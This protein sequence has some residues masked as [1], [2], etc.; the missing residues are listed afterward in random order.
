[1]ALRTLL[2]LAFATI[3]FAQPDTGALPDSAADGVEP[4]TRPDPRPTIFGF[5]RESEQHKVLTRLLQSTSNISSTLNIPGSR[6]TVF[7]P[8]DDAFASLARKLGEDGSLQATDTDA[9]IAAIATVLRKIDSVP[10]YLGVTGILFYHVINPALTYD[11]LEEMGSVK[12]LV[13]RNLTFEDDRI[14]D[15][16]PSRESTSASP[17]NVFCQNGWVNSIF[18]VLLPFDSTRA[19]EISKGITR[20]TPVGTPGVTDPDTAP[21]GTP[22]PNATPDPD[23]IGPVTVDPDAS[24]EPSPTPEDGVC[25]PASATVRLADGRS[26]TMGEL[27]AGHEVVHNEAGGA[28]KV[29]LFT[30]RMH[31]AETMFYRITTAVGHAVTMTGSHYLYVNSHLAAADSV[32]VGDHVRTTDGVSVVTDVRRVKGVGLFAP[33]TQHG[34][35]VVDGIVVSG[36]SRAVSPRLAHALLLPVRFFAKWAGVREP[37]GA[38]FYE[39]GMGLERFVLGGRTRY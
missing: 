32:V 25:F 10:G 20:P 18:E 27:E 35:L 6:F 30:H 33:H 2:L 29:F 15:G 14:V 22:D 24:E 9:V 7:A 3:A 11:M 13:N 1:M 34:D 39:G 8:T 5:I 16:D 31:V 36:Y 21:D 4:I 38:T 26:L 23:S 17:K 28:S 37:L 19:V 12:T